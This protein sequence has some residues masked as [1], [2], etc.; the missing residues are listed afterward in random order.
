MLDEPTANL[1]FGNQVRALGTIR[2][3]ARQ[4]YAVLMTSHS[5]DHA[6]LTAHEV[7][8]LKD[9]AVFARGAPDEVIDDAVLS[10]LYGT[11]TV[12]ARA[13]VAGGGCVKVCDCAICKQAASETEAFKTCGELPIPAD[14]QENACFVR[15]D[16]YRFRL[17]ACRT[18]IAQF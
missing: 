5:P 7:L 9:G 15:G 10:G 3:L 8:L 14:A 18:P 4:G 13:P 17:Y 12:V 11:P 2:G 6:F 1:D 16:F